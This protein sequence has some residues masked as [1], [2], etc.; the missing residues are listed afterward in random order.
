M[1]EQVTEAAPIETVMPEAPF[2]PPEVVE[3]TPEVSETPTPQEAAPESGQAEISLYQDVM[4]KFEG[5]NNY[6]MSDE[7]I[8]AFDY[9]QEQI[10]GGLEDPALQ[11]KAEKPPEEQTQESQES[12]V[13]ETPEKNSE[14]IPAES[15]SL[16]DDNADSLQKTMTAVGAKDI[17]ELPEKVQGLI[18]K[19][20]SSGEKLGGEL[21]AL[22]AEKDNHIQWI[23]DLTA[24]KPAALEYLAKIT[25]KSLDTTL[26]AQ[27]TNIVK[28]KFN[29]DNYLDDELAQYV[30]GQDQKIAELKATVE[31]LTSGEVTRTEAA[32]QQTAVDGYVDD[33]VDLVVKNPRDFDM[34]PS[35]ARGLAKQYWGD[36][37]QALHPKFEKIDKLLR[38]AQE[39]NITFLEDAHTV[40]QHVNGDYTNKLIEATKKGQASTKHKVSVNNSLSKNAG[41]ASAQN[42]PSPHIDEKMV[43]EMINGNFE[44]IPSE[45]HD[46]DGTLIPANIPKRFHSIVGIRS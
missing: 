32:K 39:R 35:E 42:T 43:N 8:E 25:G 7:E 26:E 27:P 2:T 9:V 1:S 19:M 16:T 18:S 46:P 37:T 20:G 38:F 40:Y 29:A 13:T 12:E 23:D 45:W 28:S 31:K 24:G 41:I 3:N 30:S 4:E 33:I 5:D 17:S 14:E 10:A 36:P 44:A 6:Q 21:K 34:S 22:R 11:E 15:F